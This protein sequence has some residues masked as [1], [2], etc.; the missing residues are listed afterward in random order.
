MS[1]SQRVLVG[2]GFAKGTSRCRPCKVLVGDGLS[3]AH[4]VISL[5]KAH[6]GRGMQRQKQEV[7]GQQMLK[8]KIK[9]QEVKDQKVKEVRSLNQEVLD[10]W[11]Q[12]LSWRINR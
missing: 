1:A 10:Q 4:G 11:G 7:K 12:D 3:G 9:D 8:Q 6:G 2:V 5:L